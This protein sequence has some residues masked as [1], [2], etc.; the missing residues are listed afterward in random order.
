MKARTR[1]AR[2]ALGGNGNGVFAVGVARDRE[3]D[4]GWALGECGV[5]W[6]P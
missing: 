5:A 2:E 1:G 3:V 6:R 4:S